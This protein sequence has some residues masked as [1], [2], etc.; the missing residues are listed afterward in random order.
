ML[1]QTSRSAP[2]HP[3]KWQSAG[4]GLQVST[5]FGETRKANKILYVVA[6]FPGSISK[7]VPYGFVCSC[8]SQ[9]RC[10]LSHRLFLRFPRREVFRL[11]WVAK[12]ILVWKRE[13]VTCPPGMCKSP[14]LCWCRWTW[15]S[16]NQVSTKS[17]YC[18]GLFWDNLA[19]LSVLGWRA[20]S[21]LGHHSPF[22]LQV[23]QE[24]V[25]LWDDCP[26]R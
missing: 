23:W 21:S 11:Q 20:A 17:T 1:W 6:G 18:H 9:H 4:C 15:E 12:S 14:Q 25:M 2:P 16:S 13:W 8:F 5:H 22:Q 3:N 19:A 7:A 24:Q 10:L 26:H